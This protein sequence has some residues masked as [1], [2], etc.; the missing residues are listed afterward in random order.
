MSKDR[1]MPTISPE[2]HEQRRIMSRMTPKEK[3]AYKW[4]RYYEKATPQLLEL[5]EYCQEDNRIVPN[6]WGLI[7]GRYMRFTHRDDFTGYP[8]YKIP[9]ILGASNTPDLEKRYRFL[10]QIYWCYK[11]MFIDRMY[12]DIMRISDD[13]DDDDWIWIKGYYQ[14]D[15]VSLELIK[16]EYASWLGVKYHPEHSIWNHCTDH[17]KKHKQ[18]ER[19][20]NLY[21]NQEDILDD[22]S[23]TSIGDR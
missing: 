21:K 14:E 11:N 3:T 2:M 22:E 18:I 23:I 5:I 8:P 20:E 12:E 19:A 10:T 16:K 15:K 7:G 9:L 6:N 1:P 13:D 4:Q 17:H